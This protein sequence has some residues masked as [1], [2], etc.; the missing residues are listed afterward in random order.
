MMK[1]QSHQIPGGTGGPLQTNVSGHEDSDESP[2]P[3]SASSPQNSPLG[4][5]MRPTSGHDH[6]TPNPI[7]T[8]SDL[9]GTDSSQQQQQQNSHE[10]MASINTVWGSGV[11]LPM[12]ENKSTGVTNNPYEHLVDIKPQLVQNMPPGCYDSYQNNGGLLPPPYQYPCFNYS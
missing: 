6:N 3:G 1:V 10:P 12:V 7:G 4:T 2:S 11:V 8:R 9:D 5:P